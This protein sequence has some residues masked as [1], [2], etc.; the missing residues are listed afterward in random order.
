MINVELS[1]S[2]NSDVDWNGIEPSLCSE[3][4]VL[5]D[6]MGGRQALVRYRGEAATALS[7]ATKWPDKNDCSKKIMLKAAYKGEE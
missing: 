3:V 2:L 5:C 4:G 1:P 6:V 7:W